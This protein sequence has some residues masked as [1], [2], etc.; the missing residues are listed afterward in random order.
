LKAESAKLKSAVESLRSE[1]KRENERLA[2]ILTAKFD[3]AHDK[4]KEDFEFRLNS[5]ILIVSERIDSER[6]DNENELVK[7]SSTI[8]EVYANVSEKIDTDVTQIREA[9]AQIRE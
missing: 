3:A 9:M 6:K 2:K 5:E 1:I 4:I 8:D 7:L